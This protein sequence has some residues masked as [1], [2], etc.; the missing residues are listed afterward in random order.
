MSTNNT[1]G[2][3]DKAVWDDKAVSDM[4]FSMAEA[5]GGFTAAEAQQ[6]EQIMRNKG[7]TFT[8]KQ[9]Q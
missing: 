7:Y 1:T 8:A 3:T 6:V 9:L 5:R 4:F 2:E